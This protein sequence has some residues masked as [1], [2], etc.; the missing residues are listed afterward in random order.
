MVLVSGIERHGLETADGVALGT[1]TNVLFHP[2]E[3]RVI[4]FAVRPPNALTVVERPGTYLPLSAL[5]FGPDRAHCTLSKLPTGARA[6]KEL[7]YDPDQ[8]VIWTGM[9][10]AVAS[11]A[12]VGTV[13]DVVFDETTGA[14]ERL[15]VGSGVMAD[16]AHG[17]YLVPGAAVE[18]YRDGAIRVTADIAQLD[19]SGGFARTAAAGA[20]AVGQAAHAAGEA[21]VEGSG[22]AGRAIRAVADAD[23][24]KKVARR[25]KSTWAETAK[26]FKQGM[27]GDE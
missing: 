1:I 15:D 14:V 6:D 24:A 8:T 25:A 17:R 19:G 27:K 7:G 12:I 26:A 9:S 2:S 22:A 18:G 11:G 23:I 4:G 20:V 3:A 5:V 13:S 21:L 10:V 16:V